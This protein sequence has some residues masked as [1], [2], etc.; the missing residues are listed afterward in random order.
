MHSVANKYTSVCWCTITMRVFHLFTCVCHSLA[1]TIKFIFCLNFYLSPSSSLECVQWDILL[2]C[3]RHGTSDILLGMRHGTWDMRHETWD[4][5]HG[6]VWMLQIGSFV[7]LADRHS[8]C[9]QK[10]TMT[11][12]MNANI[13]IY[14]FHIGGIFVYNVLITVVEFYQH[15]QVQLVGTA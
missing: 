2:I 15:I 12:L 11:T 4:M 13:N 3:M 1:L 9:W 14:S 8:F 7:F 6:W 10:T 5:R